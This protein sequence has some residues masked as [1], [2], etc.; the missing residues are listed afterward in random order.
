MCY[1]GIMK[2]VYFDVKM[3]ERMLSSVHE[4][5]KRLQVQISESEKRLQGQIAEMRA[6]VK[7][8]THVA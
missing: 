5:E 3:E 2:A 8:V 1:Q 6:E 7:S 4:S